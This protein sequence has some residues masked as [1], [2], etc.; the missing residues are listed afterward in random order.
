MTFK[1]SAK[2]SAQ[3]SAQ[4]STENGLVRY[5]V[6]VSTAVFFRKVFLQFG[7]LTF[8]TVGKMP[9][10]IHLHK[11]LGVDSQAAV[12]TGAIFFAETKALPLGN[13]FNAFYS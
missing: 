3:P 1:T 2:P 10:P 13:D 5:S 11:T 4:P 7:R 9:G 6:E 8:G 12:K